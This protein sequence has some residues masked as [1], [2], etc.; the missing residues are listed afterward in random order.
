MA[1]YRQTVLTA[2]QNVEDELAALRQLEQEQ[3]VR[4]DAE[5]AAKQAEVI[6]LNQ[7][8]AGTVAF[9]SVI[10]AQA[11]SLSAQLSARQ[12]TASRLQASALLIQ[13]LG[14]GWTDAELPKM[15]HIK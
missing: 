10:T 15:S 1:V 2:F 9:T 4:D 12:V 3:R 13:A 14:G 6:A 7:Y 11:Q 5:I 8:R